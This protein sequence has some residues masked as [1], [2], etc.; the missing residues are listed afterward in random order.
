MTD[1]LNPDGLDLGKSLLSQLF[2]MRSKC[3]AL[4]AQLDAAHALLAGAEEMRASNLARIDAERDALEAKLAEVEAERDAY[5]FKW[6]AE[7][8]VR[9]EAAEAKLAERDGEIA[10]LREALVRGVVSE[11]PGDQEKESKSEAADRD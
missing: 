8:R 11:A 10:R 7:W 1:I 3:D 2:D 9:A 4:A 5:R 6:V